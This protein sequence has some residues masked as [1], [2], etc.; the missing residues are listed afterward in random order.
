MEPHALAEPAEGLAAIDQAS[1]GG[2][3]AESF[4]LRL[5]GRFSCFPSPGNTEK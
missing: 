5:Y 4:V 3:S 2:E 1:G